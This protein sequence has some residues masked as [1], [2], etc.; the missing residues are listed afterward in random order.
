MSSA[1]EYAIIIKIGIGTLSVLSI[2]GILTYFGFRYYKSSHDL[3]TNLES[4]E[5]TQSWNKELYK[6][7]DQQSIEVC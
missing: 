5:K 2:V 3:S 1:I 4:R 6:I 7:S